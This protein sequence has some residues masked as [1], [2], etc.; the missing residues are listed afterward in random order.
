MLPYAEC[1]RDIDRL[2][3]L[4]YLLD[5]FDEIKQFHG[6]RF[7]SSGCIK[8]KNG[9]V[10]F[11]V[12]KIIDRWKEYIEDLFY[13]NRADNPIQD[14]LQ[15]PK[16][17]KSEIES[18]LKRMSKGKAVGVD[19]ISAAATEESFVMDQSADLFTKNN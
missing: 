17:L 16:I 9:D 19:N 6:K 11:E 12:D 8:D 13:D 7:S 18:A 4:N 10:L 5:L 3:S 14:Y 15:G 2:S 1:V